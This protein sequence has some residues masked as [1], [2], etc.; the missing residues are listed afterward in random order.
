MKFLQRM[1]RQRE[2]VIFLIVLAVV[3]AMSF[4]SPIFLTEGNILALLLSLSIQSVMAVGMVNL[5]VGGGF[6]MSVGSILGFTGIIVAM[7][8]KAGVPPVLAVAM[9]LLAGVAIGLWN[10]IVVAKLKINPF[11]PPWL[12]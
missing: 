10:G 11:V 8:M 3:V 5:M 4:A 12:P 1:I 6:D 2:F 7:L 9:G